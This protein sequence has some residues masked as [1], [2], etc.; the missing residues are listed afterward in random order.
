[1]NSLEIGRSRQYL[2]SYQH[3]VEKSSGSREAAKCQRLLKGGQVNDKGEC[4]MV[5]DGLMYM[6]GMSVDVLHIKLMEDI[7]MQLQNAGN[8]LRH[9]FCHLCSSFVLSP[10]DPHIIPRSLAF[11]SA[12]HNFISV[13]L[14]ATSFIGLSSASQPLFVETPHS[15]SW[16]QDPQQMTSVSSTSA[17][18]QISAPLNVRTLRS[19]Q[20]WRHQCTL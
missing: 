12:L 19:L 16:L 5:S 10:S 8:N 7:N 13:V 1:M 2:L 11:F 3:R 17:M 6:A 14:E 4:G 9:Q 18:P 20:S 15:Q